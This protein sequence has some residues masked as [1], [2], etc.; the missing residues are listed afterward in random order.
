MVRKLSVFRTPLSISLSAPTTRQSR[1][2]SIVASSSSLPPDHRV[3]STG[4]WKILL[5]PAHQA[6]LP[7]RHLHLR[8]RQRP[9]RRGGILKNAHC[10]SCH[11][12]RRRRGRL[13][14]LTDHPS[15]LST[16]SPAPSLHRSS[17]RRLRYRECRRSAAWRG[18]Y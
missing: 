14:G 11:R 13:L 6:R 8:A 15:S 9:L 4:L 12:R 7:S 10:R 3:P 16:A 18:L 17:R 2:T 1:L 5:F